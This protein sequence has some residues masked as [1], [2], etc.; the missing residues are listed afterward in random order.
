MPNLFLVEVVPTA[1][2]PALQTL[3][4]VDNRVTDAGGQLIEAQVTSGG[5]RILAI[6]EADGAATVSDALAGLEAEE[7]S[8]PS[9]VPEGGVVVEVSTS[10][11]SHVVRMS[12]ARGGC[13][14]RS[15]GGRQRFLAPGRASSR[16]VKPFPVTERVRS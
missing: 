10:Q 12:G 11:R 13:L 1:A 9:P 16:P 7:V 4:A 3:A 5:G 14:T 8:E 2:V 15:A 6:I